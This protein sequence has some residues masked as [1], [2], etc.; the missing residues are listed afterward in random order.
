MRSWVQTPAQLPAPAKETKQN[1]KLPKNKQKA[2]P[3]SY[4]FAIYIFWSQLLFYHSKFPLS[5][6]LKYR[7]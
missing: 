7:Q 5:S 1:K 2:K 4:H 6:F 3:D